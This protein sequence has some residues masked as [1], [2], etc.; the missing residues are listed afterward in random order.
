MKKVIKRVQS[1][2]NIQKVLKSLG[3]LFSEKILRIV[4]GFFVTAWIARHLGPESYGKYTFIIQYVLIFLPIVTFGMNELISRDIVQE[5]T[6]HPEGEVLGTATF[7]KVINSFIGIGIILATIP[8]VSITKFES[9]ILLGFSSI[10]FFQVFSVVDHWYEAK[11]EYRKLVFARNFGYLVGVVAKIYFLIEKNSFEYFVLA[12]LIELIVTKGIAFYTY[13]KMNGVSHWS[14]NDK[15]LR[16]YYKESLPLFLVSALTIVEQKIGFVFVK[17]LNNPIM[18]GQFS[19]AFTMYNILIFVPNA[20][21][22]ALFPTIIRSKQRSESLY[23]ERVLKLFFALFWSS[24]FFCIGLAA[25]GDSFINLLFGEKY[26]SSINILK[27]LGVLFVFVS[28][29][30][31]RKKIL[32]LEGHGKDY[33]AIIGTYVSSSLVLQFFLVEKYQAV[34]VVYG[35]TIAFIISNIVISIM[36]TNIRS[37]SFMFM[38][39]ILYPLKEK[40]K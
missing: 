12:Y 13:Y 32:I 30:A 34:G 25:L 3:F 14:V 35:S 2:E 4:V 28:F 24:L 20:I 15:L 37:V 5:E 27:V 1:T 6:K 19:L 21:V 11:L 16:S 22:T 31:A 18:L 39:G 23:Y 29:D 8:F 40:A 33:F 17:K 26:E 10:L 36:N 7:I 9:Y 38:K